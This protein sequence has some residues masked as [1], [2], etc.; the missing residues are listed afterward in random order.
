MT[1]TFASKCLAVALFLSVPTVA[2]HAQKTS[3]PEERTHWT[4]VL[5]K[6]EAKPND[7]QN[8]SDAEAVFK[9]LIEVSDFHMVIC[10]VFTELPSGYGKKH[11]IM[12]LFTLGLAAYQVETGKA[13]NEGAN[14][15]ALHS[16]LKGYAS[17][18]A[19]DPKAKDKKLDELA[20][21]D[22]EGQLPE[23]IVKHGCKTN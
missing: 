18:L 2:A 12:Q 7:P 10:P 6:L 14:L 16:V 15:Y 19:A 1:R 13:D 20:K 5:H 23:F 22:A 3:T 21:M 4:E 9:R 17:I 8:V 11:P